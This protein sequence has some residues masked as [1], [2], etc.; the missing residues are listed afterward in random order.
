MKHPAIRKVMTI[1]TVRH[2]QSTAHHTLRAKHSFQIPSSANLPRQYIAPCSRR[3]AT[4]PA[5]RQFS[6]SRPFSLSK[7]I[8]LNPR[9]IDRICKRS[10]KIFRLIDVSWRLKPYHDEEGLSDRCDSKMFMQAWKRAP[11]VLNF[12]M[13]SPVNAQTIGSVSRSDKPR[14]RY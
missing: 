4:N 12:S 8:L 2:A 9:N 7:S 3:Y 14:I 5:S 6:N 10:L 13:K 1:K 11:D